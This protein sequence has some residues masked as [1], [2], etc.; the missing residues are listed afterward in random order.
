M[1]NENCLLRYFSIHKRKDSTTD[2]GI[3]A[4]IDISINKEAIRHGRGARSLAPE[5]S[6]MLLGQHRGEHRGR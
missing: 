4:F 2:Q 1:T 3:N 6:H 5:E